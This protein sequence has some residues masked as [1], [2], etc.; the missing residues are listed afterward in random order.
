MKLHWCDPE[1]S[2]AGSLVSFISLFLITQTWR[3]AQWEEKKQTIFETLI[4]WASQISVQFL[5]CWRWSQEL[6]VL[7]T[8]QFSRKSWQ[9]IIQHKKNLFKLLKSSFRHHFG[10]HSHGISTTTPNSSDRN[11]HRRRNV[12]NAFNKPHSGLRLHWNTWIIWRFLSDLFIY[13]LKLKVAALT[14][15]S[16][17]RRSLLPLQTGK[18]WETEQSWRWWGMERGRKVERSREHPVA[19]ALRFRNVASILGANCSVIAGPPRNWLGRGRT[20]PCTR[21]AT[22]PHQSSQCWWWCHQGQRRSRHHR[23]KREIDRSG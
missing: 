18:R 11:N 8:P 7:W 22:I 13:H 3:K 5:V 6:T 21:L 19:S 15:A 12:S 4:L 10:P 1:L 9:I 20:R 17:F 23:L 16:E 14:K 2:S